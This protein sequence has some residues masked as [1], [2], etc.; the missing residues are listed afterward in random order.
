MI[1]NKIKGLLNITNKTTIELCEKLNILNVVY[2]RKIKNNTFKAD[3][4]I[5]IADLTNTKLAFI[6]NDGKP[7]VIL[8][9]DDIK[10]DD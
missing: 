2:Y 8:D 3:E 6:N 5:K 1:G 4:L 10:S 7:I 9:N